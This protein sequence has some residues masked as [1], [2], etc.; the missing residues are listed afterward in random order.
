[1]TNSRRI[2]AAFERRLARDIRGWLGAD[3]QRR[4]NDQQASA[5]EFDITWDGGTFPWA[6]EAKAH[7]TF[8]LAQLWT[9]QGPM[10]HG[11]GSRES[12]WEQTTRQAKG[13]G[14]KPLLVINV[15]RRFV[16]AVMR[17][18]DLDRLST[19]HWT[20]VLDLESASLVAVL[21]DELVKTPPAL[22]ARLGGVR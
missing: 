15:P 7:K 16:L 4:R 17:H 8:N 18:R 13:A 11:A 10:W 12:W 2:G 9:R 3:V 20:T 1:M 6:L 14:L 5:G 19:D 22:V 21:W